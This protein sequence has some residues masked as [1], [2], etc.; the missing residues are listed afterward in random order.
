M[1]RIRTPIE[2]S[3]GNYLKFVSL[4]WLSKELKTVY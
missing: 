3:E 1:I 4:E 2:N